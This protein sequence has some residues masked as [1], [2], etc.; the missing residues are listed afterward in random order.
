MPVSQ[1]Q[2]DYL[3]NEAFE[4]LGR[5]LYGTDW[6]GGELGAQEWPSPDD[7]NGKRHRLQSTVAALDHDIQELEDQRPRTVNESEVKVI[8]DRLRKLRDKRAEVLIEL[9][10]HPVPDKSFIASLTAS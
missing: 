4:L 1:I 7:W 10:R 3:L 6:T 8:E 5:K 2:R 9:A